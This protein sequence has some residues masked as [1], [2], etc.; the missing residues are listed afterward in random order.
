MHRFASRLA[1]PSCHWIT[2]LFGGLSTLF[3]TGCGSG[4]PIRE[5]EVLKPK[6]VYERNHLE[7]EKRQ[8][9]G[10]MIAQGDTMWFVKVM[11]P[12]SEVSPHLQPFAKF[13]SSIKF[14]DDTSDPTWI[15]PKGWYEAPP[16]DPRNGGMFPRYATIDFRKL[17][18]G[19][20]DSYG[21]LKS[22][23]KTDVAITKLKINNPSLEEYLLSNINRWRE[24]LEISPATLENLFSPDGSTLDDPEFVERQVVDDR[25]IVFVSLK[26][27]KKSKKK[28]PTANQA[29]LPAGH[30]PIEGHPPVGPPKNASNKSQSDGVKSQP[31]TLNFQASESWTKRDSG[32]NYEVAFD[33]E[34]GD[35][36]AEVT[37]M[38]MRRQ[39]GGYLGFVNIWAESVGLEPMNSE[40]INELKAEIE[41]GEHTGEMFVLNSP[42]DA[43]KKQAVLG[44]ILPMNDTVWSIKFKG[45]STLAERERS[46]FEAFVKSITPRQ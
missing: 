20:S 36:K 11:G 46:N 38:R 15:L 16:D 2:L 32:G 7:L 18:E 44:V 3:L 25:E 37:V 45:S 43:E 30:P 39:P 28:S 41:V 13:V 21:T 26:E 22:K 4:E 6:F 19:D 1:H 8:L 12:E 9:L 10:A 42:D 35:E 31:V 5:Y 40:Q 29:T 34:E 33:L 17:S 27:T 24:Q 23:K 14:E